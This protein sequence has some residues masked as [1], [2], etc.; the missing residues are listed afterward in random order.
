MAGLGRA[1]SDIG[2]GS[3]LSTPEGLPGGSLQTGKYLQA[4]NGCLS[5]FAA[6]PC[7]GQGFLALTEFWALLSAKLSPGSQTCSAS[8]GCEGQGAWVL[9]LLF[10]FLDGERKASIVET[11]LS[12]LN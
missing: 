7:T 4:L 6:L 11:G 8:L 9:V 12:C 3:P 1:L 10:A 5:S 2:K